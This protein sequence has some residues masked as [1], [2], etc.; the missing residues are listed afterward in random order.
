MSAVNVGRHNFLC[1]KKQPLPKS[2]PDPYRHP[3]PNPNFV[4]VEIRTIR[5]GFMTSRHEL[6][7]IYESHARTT[8]YTAIKYFHW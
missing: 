1:T 4:S 6:L 8:L 3:N 5:G 7:H 2:N